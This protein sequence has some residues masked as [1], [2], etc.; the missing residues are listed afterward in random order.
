MEPN[1]TK[2][3]EVELPLVDS[4]SSTY[5]HDDSCDPKLVPGL[6]ALSF[7]TEQIQERLLRVLGRM[8]I[9]KKEEESCK[10]QAHDVIQ[11]ILHYQSKFTIYEAER[12]A[13]AEKVSK[14]RKAAYLEHSHDM[15][16]KSVMDD[17]LEAVCGFEEGGHPRGAAISLI[18]PEKGDFAGSNMAKLQLNKDANETNKI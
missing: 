8:E 14:K 2:D 12:R 3:S 6:R 11:K 7:T 10:K 4:E 17:L 15:Q 1:T 5:F 9:I 16:V 13:I 18:V